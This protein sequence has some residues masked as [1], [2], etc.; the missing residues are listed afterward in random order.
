MSEP[1][2]PRKLSLAAM[3]AAAAAT[4][5][6]FGIAYSLVQQGSFVRIW[7]DIVVRPSGPFGGRFILQ[8]IM[9]SIIAIGDGIA[10][11]RAGR[12]P[13]Y[14][15]IRHYADGRNE[16]LFEGLKAVGNVISIAVILDT[17]YQIAVMRSFYWFE[18]ILVAGL[19]AFLPYLVVRGL[20]DRA[21]R[22]F[23]GR[24]KTGGTGR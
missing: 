4:V 21:A 7:N 24:P 18:T 11:A 9:A 2:T 17:V 5:F 10:D 1:K 8:P 12:P 15:A 6:V 23:V 14:W 20:A 13:Y 22:R 16:R 19:L 3:L